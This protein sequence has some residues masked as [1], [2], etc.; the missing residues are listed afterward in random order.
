MLQVAR[1]LIHGITEKITEVIGYSVATSLAIIHRISVV[2]VINGWL[3]TCLLITSIAVGIATF[4]YTMIQIRQ[5]NK[6][7]S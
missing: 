1:V 5:S 7:K 6:P 4:I 2:E 3:Q